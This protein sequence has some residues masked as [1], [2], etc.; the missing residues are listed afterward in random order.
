[1][2]PVRSAIVGAIDPDWPT[3]RGDRRID[4]ARVGGRNRHIDLDDIVGQTV[5]HNLCPVVAAILRAKQTAVGARPRS[6][7]PRTFLPLPHAGV[8]NIRMLGIDLHIRPAG[9]VVDEENLLEGLSAIGGAKDA[10]LFIRS[11]WMSSDRDIHAVGIL[12]IDCNLANGLSV[13]QPQMRPALAAVSR[14]IDAIAGRQ[15]GPR[16]PLTARNIHYI[17]IGLRHGNRSDRARRLRIPQALPGSSGVRC[18]PDTAIHRSEVKRSRLA[19]NPRQGACSPSP[20]RTDLAP[21]H[22]GEK[23]WTIRAALRQPRPDITA[24]KHDS[25]KPTMTADSHRLLN[26]D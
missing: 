10:A 13:A 21:P 7:L 26:S 11:I 25:K 5:P 3:L 12:R 16:Q 18:F 15:I 19:R 8:H 9:V 20:H 23:L 22:F 24:C 14:F 17:W 6:V 1:M 4:T 2:D